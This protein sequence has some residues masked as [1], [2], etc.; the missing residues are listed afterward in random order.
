MSKFGNI[1]RGYEPNDIE[2]GPSTAFLD[3]S[4]GPLHR[5]ESGV[6]QMQRHLR[7]VHQLQ[8]LTVLKQE[9]MMHKMMRLRR[10][11]QKK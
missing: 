11:P 2:E 1:F 5:I 10:M 6:V 7:E 4:P 3:F 9:L 8:E